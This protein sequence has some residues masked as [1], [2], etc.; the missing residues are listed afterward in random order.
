MDNEKVKPS[1]FLIQGLSTL[2]IAYLTSLT[3]FVYAWPSYT[4]ENFQSNSTVLNTPMSLAEISLL[5]SLTNVGALVVTPFC[6]YAVDKFGRKYSAMLF[7]LP[8]V[9]SW[10]IIS[11]TKSVYLVLFSVTLAGVGAAGQ[12]VSSIYISEISQDSIRGALTSTTVSGFFT[13]LLFSYALGGYL[14]YKQ[15][16]Y[17]HL[18]LSILYILLLMLLK[19]SPVFL[20]MSGKEKE[21]A[22]SIAFYRRVDVTSKE[23]DIEIKK[24][25]LQLDPRIVN[26]LQSGNDIQA[27]KELI[28]TN[29][30]RSAIQETK[31]ETPWQFLKRSE[32]SKRALLAVLIVMAVVILMGSIVL[33][34][35]AEALFK[36]A[37]P[38]MHPNTCSIWLAVVYLLASLVCAAMLDRFGRK[39]LMTVTSIL[40]GIFNMLLASQLQMRWAPHWFTAFVIYGYSFVYNLGAAVVPYVLTAE[41]FLPEVRGL[42][43]SFSMACMWITNFVTLIIFNPLVEALGLGPTF[44]IFAGVCFLGAVYSHTCLPE[45]KGLSADKIQPLFMK[46]LKRTPSKYSS[47]AKF[48]DLWCGTVDCRKMDSEKV[49]PSAFLIQGLST[50]IIAYLTSL[51]GFVYAWPS[52]TME[53]FQSNSTVLST[54]MSLAEISLLG[55]LTNIGA[56]IITPFCGY[57]VDKFGRKYSAM[58]FGLPFVISWGIISVTK[59]VYLVLFSISLAGVGAAGQGISSIYISE[60]SQD[61]IRGALTSTTVSGF[62]TGL[63][64]SYALG[65]YLSYNQVVY[66]HLSL[67]ILYILLLMLLKESPVFLLMSGKE[68][69]AAESIAFYRRVDVTSKEVEIEIKKIYLQLDPRIDNILQSG[70]DIQATKELIE[71]NLDKSAVQETKTETPWQFLKRSESSKRALLAVLIVMAV[72]ILMGSIVLQVYAEALF[73]EALPNMHP[74]TCSI[75]LAVV[76]LLASLVCAAMLDRFGRKSLMTVTSILSGIF[77]TLLASQLH[78]RWAPHWFTAFVIYGYSFVYNLGAAVVP[79]VLTAEVFLPEVRGLCNSFSMACMWITNFVTL[80]IFN[81]LVEALGLGPT[82]YIFAGVCFLGAVYSHTCLPETKGLSADKIQPL[83]MKKQKRTPSKA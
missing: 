32:S 35:Y 50:L 45:T 55:S 65:G 16:V 74:N 12:G 27:A 18:S 14:S 8:I 29:H 1:A 4:M 56:L 78:M 9:I 47:K 38:N 2:I 15:V 20:L 41:V 51:T 13:G 21:A 7:G 60:I 57:A 76:Y 36:E 62:F 11:V 28:E 37:L 63:L 70:N 33:Q 81:P 80:I 44:Y 83:F 66:V 40:S 43:N 69:E 82:F 77:N 17:V 67:S 64:F 23:V 75:W 25:Y 79:F 68:K 34:V 26:K 49:K 10:G 24:I 42:C 31:T 6:G 22:E 46:K 3:G 59:S 71:K 52:Y 54:P 5:G 58:L 48:V 61:S 73:K 39:S 30:D 19:E 53:N 72:V